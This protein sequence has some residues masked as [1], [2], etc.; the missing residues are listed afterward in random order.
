MDSED[1]DLKLAADIDEDHASVNAPENNE[2]SAF[3]EKNV[4]LGKGRLFLALQ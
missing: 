1:T 2:S 4:R 3:S